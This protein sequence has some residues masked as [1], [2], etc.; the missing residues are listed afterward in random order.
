[1]ENSI[2]LIILISQESCK[3]SAVSMDHCQ[4]EWTKVLV[5][6]EI[7]KIVVDVEK[8]S[9]FEILWRLSVRNPIE[10]VYREKGIE[11]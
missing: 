2:V 11:L 9:I 4:I 7:S 1:M 10:F 5:E 3:L 6:W 8:E